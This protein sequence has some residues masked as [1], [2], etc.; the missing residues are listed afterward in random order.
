MT[1]KVARKILAKQAKSNYKN[2]MISKV[3]QVAHE[4]GLKMKNV[5]HMRKSKWKKHVKGKIGKLIEKRTKQ[6]MAN[7]TK[8]RIMIE[9]K[10]ERKKYFQK[11]DSDT[12]KVLLK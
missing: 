8:A 10:W 5:D 1:I 9:D 12:I 6:G 11:C 7:K 4:I 2:T 3:K